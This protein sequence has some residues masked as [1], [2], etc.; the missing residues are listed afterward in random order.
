[1]GCGEQ[2]A[3]GSCG[4]LSVALRL[5]ILFL[6]LNYL[7]VQFFQVLQG[8]QIRADSLDR[9]VRRNPYTAGS[10]YGRRSSP[11]TGSIAGTLASTRS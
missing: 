5:A 2:L 10:P 3:K 7:T 1:M 11:G 8:D 9:I 4:S 6:P